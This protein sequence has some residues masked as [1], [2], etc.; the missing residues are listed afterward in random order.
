VSS[1][2]LGEGTRLSC[3]VKGDPPLT[4]SWFKDS[5]ENKLIKSD[6]IDMIESMIDNGIK[7]QL[8]IR[9]SIREDNGIYYC[10]ANNSFGR[11][12]K[13]NKLVVLEAPPPPT[14]LS[15]QKV[16]SR[17][18]SLSWVPYSSSSSLTIPLTGFTI[19]FW[20]ENVG[21]N[22]RLLEKNVSG[23]QTEFLLDQLIPGTTYGFTVSAVNEVGNS[24][25][26]SSMKF[27]TGEEEPDAAPVD[28]SAESK[29]PTTI[30]VTWKPPPKENWNGKLE[31]FYVGFKPIHESG[32][33][34]FHRTTP[35]TSF[36]T[37]F[38]HFIPGLH[39]NTQYSI[40][41]K[42][43]NMAGSGPESIPVTAKT[44]GDNFIE[45]PRV[46]VVSVSSDSIS[47]HCKTSKSTS[48]P[49]DGTRSLTGFVVHLRPDS[50]QSYQEVSLPLTQGQLEASFVAKDLSPDTLY[51]FYVTASSTGSFIEG[52]PSPVL[53]LRTRSVRDTVT[54]N[55]GGNTGL[56][57][58]TTQA[59][60][61][62]MNLFVNVVA[63]VFVVM[64]IIISFTLVK[65]AKLKAATAIPAADYYDDSAF[66]SV[67]KR[68]DGGPPPPGL[69]ACN[70]QLRM[71]PVKNHGRPLPEPSVYYDTAQ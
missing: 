34:Y 5:L 61:G 17:S 64:T 27:K 7:S 67:W 12:N 57:W 26:S 37:S 53:S 15:V 8:V 29:G 52:D 13:T 30:R 59:N 40:I 14:G 54:T 9:N 3:S 48:L 66:V 45:P 6:R 50:G 38:E 24:V 71:I 44:F 49:S 60:E 69:N 10:V 63:V 35:F 18:A 31:G 2:K 65:K 51:H 22:N 43:F 70:T 47:L 42:A 16:W 4:I 33:H 68:F 11:D 32:K 23:S 62:D 1:V 20:R 55:P 46:H 21:D 56:S 39:H 36:N 25:P 58:P 19:Q 41:V 28:V